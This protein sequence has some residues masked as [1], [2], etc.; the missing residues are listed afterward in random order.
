[1]KKFVLFISVLFILFACASDGYKYYGLDL[2][3]VRGEEL[4]KGKMLA[5]DPKDDLNLSE[6]LP[7]GRQK[8][9]CVAMFSTEFFKAMRDIESLKSQ[10]KACQAGR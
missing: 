9:P 2:T 10:L 4:I 6:C 1:M 5:K 8:S 7:N 3:Q